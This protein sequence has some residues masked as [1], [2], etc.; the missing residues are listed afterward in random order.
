MKSISELKEDYTDL[1]KKLYSLKTKKAIEKC[2]DKMADIRHA[3]WLQVVEQCKQ[4]A[5]CTVKCSVRYFSPDG[6]LILDTPYGVVF[7][8][9]CND[10][11]SK[12]WY[13]T[14]CCVEYVVDQ[15]VYLELDFEAGDFSIEVVAGRVTGGV[16]NK[17]KYHELCND[18][19]K[20]AF[21]K[22]PDAAGVTGLFA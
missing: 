7:T 10:A 8:S 17:E 12:S 21:F 11:L 3:A 19:N 4:Y 22:Y 14:T 5:R 6:E 13:G 15:V 9:A 1:K 16:L 2:R 18:G 20:Y